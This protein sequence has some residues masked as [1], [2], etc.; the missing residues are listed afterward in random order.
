MVQSSFKRLQIVHGGAAV[1]NAIQD[2]VHLDRTHTAGNAFTAAF[3]HAEFH[4]ELGHIDHAAVLVHHDQAAGSHDGAEF[5]R[6]S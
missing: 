4:E 1:G 2:A 3:V 5:R 6:L